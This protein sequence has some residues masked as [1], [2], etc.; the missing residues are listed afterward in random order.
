MRKIESQMNSAIRSRSSFSS[1]NTSVV[2]DDNNAAY[3]YLHGN[4]IATIDNDNVT[5]FDGGW[6]SNTTKSRLNAIL[7]EFAYGV[8]VFQKQW[9]WFVCNQNK[10]VDFTNGMQIAL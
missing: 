3:V 1:A 9:E 5:L 8:G 7:Q 10:T 4:H 2:I 6:Q